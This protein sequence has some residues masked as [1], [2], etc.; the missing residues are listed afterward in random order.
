VQDESAKP[1]EEPQLGEAP[2]QPPARRGWAG[3]RRWL[4]AAA[5]VVVVAVAG[6]I[7]GITVSGGS[8]SSG[9]ASAASKYQQAYRTFHAT[10][11]AQSATLS[12]DMA[13][14]RGSGLADPAFLAASQDAKALSATYQQYASSVA[15]IAVPASAKR[16]A[17]RVVQVARAGSFLM[18]QAGDFFTPDGMQAAL[19]ADWPL[20]KTE[21]TKAEKALSAALG[22]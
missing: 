13:K 22:S 7:T 15:A 14:A 19:N 21:L 3:R 12:A 8:S 5:I 17:A 11:T 18:D 10:F 2:P 9:Q 1:V 4:V 6:T 20:V 16:A